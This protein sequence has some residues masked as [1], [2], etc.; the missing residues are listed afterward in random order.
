M[1]EPSDS[2]SDLS[3]V[4]A[5]FEQATSDT[6]KQ[7]PFIWQ[8]L[9][10][11]ILV[12][13]I[14]LGA[15]SV[16]AELLRTKLAERRFAEL[17][18]FSDRIN[19]GMFRLENRAELMA[20]YGIVAHLLKQPTLEVEPVQAFIQQLTSTEPSFRM[21]AVLDGNGR[22]MF[23]QGEDT[24]FRLSR[25]ELQKSIAELE[26]GEIYSSPLK[27][28]G[29]H[30]HRWLLVP[31]IDSPHGAKAMLFVVEMSEAWKKFQSID[32]TDGAPLILVDARGNCFGINRP[33]KVG[34]TPIP[35][36]YPELW[37]RME[38][39]DFGQMAEG[40]L[41]FIYMQVRPG[42]QSPVY[43]LTYLDSRHQHTLVKRYQR[44]I[45]VAA[46]IIILILA[47]LMWHRRY[48][49]DHSRARA[50]AEQLLEHLYHGSQGQMIFNAEGRC[51]TANHAAA[52][53]V[54]LL[55][56]RLQ[57]R[58]FRHLF[59][60]D[61]LGVDM[62]WQLARA[63]GYWEGRLGLR[64]A[65]RL[66]VKAKV[67]SIVL[68][69]NERLFLVTLEENRQ[70]QELEQQ[71]KRV[72]QLTDS[73]SGLALIDANQRLKSVNRALGRI[74]NQPQERLLGV[75]WL[76]L[77]KLTNSDLEQSLS[78]QLSNRGYW[79]GALWMK[80]G[81]GG[82]VR[83]LANIH[84][85][86]SLGHDDAYQVLTL[87]PLLDQKLNNAVPDQ[88]ERP[89]HNLA[90]A[91]TQPPHT[92]AALMLF[93]QSQHNALANFNDSDA[94]LFQQHRLVQLLDGALPR[95]ALLGEAGEVGETAVL[96]PG[97]SDSQATTLASSLVSLLEEGD[98][99]DGLVIGLAQ[100][101]PGQ[102]WHSLLDNARD[103]VTRATLS[104][105][106]YCQAH[107]RSSA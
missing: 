60:S 29:R 19:D 58:R 41:H 74:L 95:E 88:E 84:Q 17:Q 72:E 31:V 54:D 70:Q 98:L 11:V 43:L 69:D 75:S 53:Q 47:R 7:L 82:V 15:M 50:R 39:N 12:A 32:A 62:I 96:L 86:D 46:L 103:A 45:T 37:D 65:P 79:Q 36:A 1:S 20:Q 66:T 48:Q 49:A 59:D 6:Q 57:D 34:R 10:M 13:G 16:N 92:S 105:Q 68:N 42:S 106:H 18:V 23:Q 76:S 99:I 81:D 89:R 55:P 35:Q 104:G 100:S 102:P 2:R 27:L 67:R 78:H 63:S 83:C 38:Q 52:T 101:Q 25:R 5:R 85:G 90:R 77:L 30:A 87:T 14:A 21:I 56:E 64:H 28:E 97:W 91:L 51:I 44:Q 24:Y 107:T 73:A 80:R 3:Q 33:E 9:L 93:N 22:P 26:P 40:P 8:L 61:S 4:L 71:L 94:L